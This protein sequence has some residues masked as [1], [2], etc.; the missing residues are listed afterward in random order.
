MKALALEI[1]DLVLLDYEMP[2]VDGRQVLGMIRDE[3]E[4]ANIPV[5]FLTGK[6]DAESVKSV[7]SLKPEGYLLKTEEP[8]KIIAEIDKF[9][10]K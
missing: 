2:I 3:P 9:F 4:Y 6:S 1:P 8:A 10:S 7:L 5:I